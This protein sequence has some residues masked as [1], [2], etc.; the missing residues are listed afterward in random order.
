MK[1]Y[2][3]TS[4]RMKYLSLFFIVFVFNLLSLSKLISQV[5][6]VVISPIEIFSTD[7]EF[8]MTITNKQYQVKFN[9]LSQNA[10][11]IP[12]GDVLISGDTLHLPYKV[13]II[14]MT[15]AV[16]LL[17]KTRYEWNFI[18]RWKSI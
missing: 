5:C 11:G 15:L 7:I 10:F 12:A 9:S 6:T 3:K 18:G 4:L 13:I 8:E 2:R 16:S 1:S 17:A 14:A